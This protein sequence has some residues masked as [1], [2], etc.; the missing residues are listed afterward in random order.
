MG[1]VVVVAATAV[2][3]SHIH[4]SGGSSEDSSN[5]ISSSGDCGGGSGSLGGDGDSDDA[6]LHQATFATA[7]QTSFT[8]RRPPSTTSLLIVLFATH[9]P[10]F[11]RFTEHMKQTAVDL[12]TKH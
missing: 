10:L 6:G 9:R 8:T 1:R 4:G 11:T 12:H 5:I 2:D 3:Y 7:L